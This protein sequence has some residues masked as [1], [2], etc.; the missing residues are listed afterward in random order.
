MPLD[1][2]HSSP[3]SSPELSSD[4]DKN[5]F[6]YTNLPVSLEDSVNFSQRT[7]LSINVGEVHRILL[8]RQLSLKQTF[9]IERRHLRKM[10]FGSA[11]IAG[12][13]I[14]DLPTP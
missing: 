9:K 10:E 11:A 14:W 4:V 1:S 2:P 3:N 8:S 7:S 12:L 5:R 13:E 6:L